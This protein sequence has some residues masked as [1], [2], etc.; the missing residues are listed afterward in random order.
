MVSRGTQARTSGGPAS[1][2][3][4]STVPASGPPA[5][6]EPP[7]CGSDPQ[8]T[9]ASVAE[10]ARPAQAGYWQSVSPPSVHA[11]RQLEAMHRVRPAHAVAQ[12]PQ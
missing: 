9:E 12:S 7:S 6:G 5:S 4:P 3:P 11:E 1:A 2:I 8:F 10:H